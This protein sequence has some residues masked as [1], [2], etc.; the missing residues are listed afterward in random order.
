MEIRLRESSQEL[1]EKLLLKDWGL[2]VELVAKAYLKAP[3]FE[4]KAIPHWEALRESNYTWFKKALSRVDLTFYTIFESDYNKNRGVIFIEDKKYRLELI[5]PEEEYSSATEMRN[6]YRETNKLRIS[7]DYSNHPYFNMVDNIVFRTVHDFIVHIQ[8]DHEFGDKGE[9]ATYNLHAKICPPNARPALFTEII[10]Q[11][12]CAVYTGDF[13][14]QKITVLEGFD[15]TNVGGVDDKDYEIVG[16]R[17]VKKET[18][19]DIEED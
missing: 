1:E 9:M 16:K 14:E 7:I 4:K 2:Y 8:G 19:P 6:S 17:L 5:T 10:G 13:P 11:V 15:Y 12:A 18:S 3:I